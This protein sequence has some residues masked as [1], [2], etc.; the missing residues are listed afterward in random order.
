MTIPTSAAKISF[1]A[2]TFSHDSM[3]AIQSADSLTE[4][5][6]LA[7]REGYFRH[8]LLVDSDLNSFRVV[9]L[10]K[11]RTLF[12][13]RFGMIL[14]LVSGNPRWQVELTFGSPTRITLQEVKHPVSTDFHRN[15]EFWEEMG[16]FEKFQDRVLSADSMAQ[17]FGTFRDFHIL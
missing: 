17:M 9:S 6:R 10:K 12:S 16:D 4:A 13:W 14:E 2:L 15:E 5:S 8:L 1:P 3:G 7:V 11:V